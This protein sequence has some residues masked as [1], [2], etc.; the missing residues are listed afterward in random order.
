M[1][2]KLLLLSNN[3]KKTMKTL[4]SNSSMTKLKFIL[5]NLLG[6]IQKFLHLLLLSK[7]SLRN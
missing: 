7:I 4:K 5:E 1:V 3:S 2:L 6:L